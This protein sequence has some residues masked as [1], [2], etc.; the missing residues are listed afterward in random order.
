M[1]SKE[2]LI[3]GASTKRMRYSNMAIQRL[4]EHGHTVIGIGKSGGNVLGGARGH[5]AS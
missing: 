2:T 4:L 5:K 1:R 3:I